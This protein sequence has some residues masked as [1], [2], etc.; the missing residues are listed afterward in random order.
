ML[1]R[2]VEG[3]ESERELGGGVHLSERKGLGEV[4]LEQGP[5]GGRRHVG[6]RCWVLLS[7]PEYESITGNHHPESVVHTGST[8][9][10]SK[11]T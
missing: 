2:E 8:L 9:D 10:R 4:T 7:S 6:R 5:Q 3:P 1:G 11:V